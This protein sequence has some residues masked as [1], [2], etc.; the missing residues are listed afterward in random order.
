M[1]FSGQRQQLRSVPW[2]NLYALCMGRA[3]CSGKLAVTR[4]A[5]RA[6]Y[7]L[8]PSVQKD[9]TTVSFA[10]N[11]FAGYFFFSCI[12]VAVGKL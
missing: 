8:R 11:T 2:A 4:V 9:S 12:G 3:G 5:G 7:A 10:W 6:T 1:T